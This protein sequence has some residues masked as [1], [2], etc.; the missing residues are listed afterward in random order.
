MG[1]SRVGDDVQDRHRRQTLTVAAKG[2]FDQL[3][4]A[5]FTDR[6]SLVGNVNGTV[7]ATLHLDDLQAPVT[8]ATIEVDGRVTLGPSLVGSVQIAAAD[9]EGRY[10]GEIADITRLHVDGPDVKLD[11]SG[12]LALGRSVD[13]RPQVPHQRA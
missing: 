6:D 9:V 1:H 8:P 2:A 7:D 12:R 3:N 11:A 5:A 10:A 4:P 13:L